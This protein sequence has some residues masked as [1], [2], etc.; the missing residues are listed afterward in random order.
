MRTQSHA[1]ASAPPFVPTRGAQPTHLE[2]HAPSLNLPM[3][4][5]LA[6]RD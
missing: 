1:H 5:L 3:T 6:S 2:S 4:R